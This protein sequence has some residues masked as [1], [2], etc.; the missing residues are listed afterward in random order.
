MAHGLRPPRS[1]APDAIAGLTVALVGLPQ[2]LAYAMMSG[3]PPAYGLATAAVPGLVAALA[4]RSS[5]V[6]TG[7]TNTTGLLLLA[8]LT[9]MLGPNGT[10]EASGLPV[11]ATLTLLTG[12]IRIVAA[13]AGAANLVRFLPESFLVGFTAGAGILIAAMQLDEALGIPTIRGA[14]LID[15]LLGV[16][17]TLGGGVLPAWPA[18]LVSF[19]TA[20]VV[21]AGQRWAPRWPLALLAVLAASLVA[22]ATGAD[23]SVGL[24]LVSDKAIVPSG[25]PAG[26]LPDLH[27]SVIARMLAPAA[28][29]AL[30]GTL[31]LTVTSTAS[32]SRPDLKREICAQ[33]WANIVGAFASAYP[34]SASLG[35][36][37]LLRIAGGRTRAAAAIAAIAVIPLLLFAAPLVGTIPQASLAGILFAIAWKMIDGR[38]MA[39]AM[40]LWRTTRVVM[41]ASLVA[42]LLLPLELAVFAGAGVALV[43][44]LAE[45]SH[46]HLR[47]WSIGPDGL[48]PHHADALGVAIE[49]NGNLHFAA[50][51][52]L[53]DELLARVPASARVVVVDLTHAHAVRWRALNALD[54]IAAVLE[55][56]GAL[57]IVC[58]APERLL[59]AIDRMGSRLDACG[60]EELPGAALERAVARVAAQLGQAAPNQ[61]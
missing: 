44:H 32:G 36:S 29:I 59:L 24:P 5:Q 1:L 51:A 52:G 12:V 48:G 23:A 35:R 20:A 56:R 10:L 28:A 13:R 39:R 42:T 9:P 7:P 26:A 33:G 14:G 49:V 2:C 6:I 31:E 45:D 11:L 60:R 22:A 19:G 40:T 54:E 3:L 50:A 41:I 61:A 34:A 18:V 47:D 58:G 21:L 17:G 55:Q 57:L 37:A 53:P 43:L 4:G 16:G 8:A 25:W 27:P 15:E 38:R 30:L 46:P